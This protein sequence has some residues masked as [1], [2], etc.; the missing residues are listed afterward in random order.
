MPY[1]LLCFDS[2]TTN[3]GEL[4]ELSIF[5]LD[6]NEIFHRYFRPR[7]KSWPTDIH[8][9]TPEMVAK[10][11]RFSA[12]KRTVQKLINS[13]P[14]LLGCA[15]SNDLH[16]LRRYGINI[17]NKHTF[18]DIQN[19]YWLLN[20]A[21]GRREKNQT[22]LSAIAAHYGLDFG[23]EQPHSATA[24]TRLTLECFKAMIKHFKNSSTEPTT[25]EQL[26]EILSDYQKAYDLALNEYRMRNSSGYINVIKRDQGFSF[27]YTRF[28]QNQDNRVVLSV[29]VTDRVKAET[30]LRANFESKQVRGFTGIYHFDESDFEFIRTYKNEID[31]ESFIARENAKENCKLKALESKVQ[32]VQKQHRAKKAI[33]ARNEDNKASKLQ[34]NEAKESTSTKKNRKARASQKPSPKRAATLAMRSVRKI[35]N[36]N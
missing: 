32:Q 35:K 14:Y 9:I 26:R 18:I 16:T 4:L 29:P 3:H 17:D 7:A 10:E 6:G 25:V 2:E 33:S 28:E 36:K 34:N 24:D 27:R 13:S 22:G 21:S 19:W 15:L 5:N 31:I 20:D 12:S 8:H 30:D 1:P 11:K 23:T